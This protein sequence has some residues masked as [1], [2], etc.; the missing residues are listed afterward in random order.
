MRHSLTPFPLACK[1]TRLM[2]TDCGPATR[3]RP[4]GLFASDKILYPGSANGLEVLDHAHPVFRPV[5]LVNVCQQFAREAWTVAAVTGLASSPALTILDS[6]SD[7]GLRLAMVV[8]PATGTGIPSPRVCSA[9]STVHP[10]RRD[11]CG[12]GL[13]CFHG[14]IR[15]FRRTSFPMPQR[16]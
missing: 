16:A 9:Q 12:V 2:N 7:T 14:I 6:T 15:I 5:T 3:A 1:A 4:L 11:Q 13:R 10:T 8:F